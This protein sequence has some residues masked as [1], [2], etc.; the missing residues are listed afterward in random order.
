[1]AI[2]SCDTCRHSPVP[3]EE[4]PCWSCAIIGGIKFNWE[5][6]TNADRIR[7]MTDD[8][9]AS[10]LYHVWWIAAWCKG[11]CSGDESCEPCWLNWLKQ[12]VKE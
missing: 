7:S 1:M 9:M 8:E 5:A 10:Y 11:G 6:R 4:E 2:I 12:E 3:T